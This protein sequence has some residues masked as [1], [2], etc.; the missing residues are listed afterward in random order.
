M[1]VRCY[2]AEHT[3][4]SRV[5]F[6]ARPL[7]A[8]NPGFHPLSRVI[9]AADFAAS[10][11]LARSFAPQRMGGGGEMQTNRASKVLARALL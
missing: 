7:L 9:H 11:A 1:M 6:P 8:L 10:A 3:V 5:P 2:I 4:A